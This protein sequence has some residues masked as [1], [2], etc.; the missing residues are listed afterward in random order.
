MIFY[1]LTGL[2]LAAMVFLVMVV[3]Q[4]FKIEKAITDVTGATEFGVK[5][6]YRKDPDSNKQ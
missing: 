3:I 4:L 1:I 6:N 2:A 5:K